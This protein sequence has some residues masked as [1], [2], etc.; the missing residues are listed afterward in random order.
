MPVFIAAV[1]PQT[2][3]SRRH[4]AT[5]ARP[6][7]SVYCRGDGA[8]PSGAAGRIA[9]LRA[10]IDAGCA[11]C[12]CSMPSRP[13][14]SD[15]ENP[16]PLTVF[17][18]ITTGRCAASAS[19]SAIRISPMSW[20]SITPTYARSSSSNSRP[21]AHSDR[22]D[23]LICGPMRSKRSPIPGRQPRQAL[24]DLL[25]D[26]VQAGL[27]AD[28]VEVPRQRPD[29]RRDRHAVVVEHDD[30]RH[31]EPA[32]VVQRLE[33]DA[34]CQRAVADHRDDAAIRRGAAQHRRLDPDG[35]GQRRRRMAGAHDVVLGFEDRAERREPAVLA[36]RPQRITP[37]GQDL[38]RVG[39]MADV[40]QDLVARRV[41][42]AVDGHGKLARPQVGSEMPA[43]LADRV[44]QLVADLLR[45][46]LQ[47]PDRERMQVL[48]LAYAIQ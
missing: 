24:L 25:A 32:G 31:V 43:D 1:M 35:V 10:T 40:P 15:G 2:R 20:P 8:A 22:I 18:W 4:S 44:D 41:Q 34:A 45:D 9:G 27:E 46:L 3:S 16:L 23:S 47:L 36:D 17:T 19:R 30:D 11:A 5:S 29:V 38:V 42:Q 12:H 39:L 13:P 7:T 37:P 21:G 6:K 48:R 28:P 26:L 14:F 33:R